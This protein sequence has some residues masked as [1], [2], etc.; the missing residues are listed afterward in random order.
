MA[1]QIKLYELRVKIDGVPYVHEEQG[2]SIDGVIKKYVNYQE[3]LYGITPDRIEII[4]VKFKSG[5]G[6]EVSA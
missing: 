3:H 2:D 5:D 1:T 4:A 6:R